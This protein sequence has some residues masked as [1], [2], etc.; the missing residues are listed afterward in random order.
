MLQAG[1]TSFAKI[2]KLGT[3]LTFG[4]SGRG[5]GQE[6]GRTEGPHTRASQG[7]DLS[8]WPA[9]NPYQVTRSRGQSGFIE[10]R[11]ILEVSYHFLTVYVNGIA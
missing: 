2:P 1:G 9:P 6:P 5:A 3:V 10:A 7:W 8:F 11:H 4:G